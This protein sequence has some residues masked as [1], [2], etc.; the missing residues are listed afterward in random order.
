MDLRRKR[1]ITAMVVTHDIHAAK[2]FSDL[3]ILLDK[4]RIVAQGTFQDL[5]K[6]DN[7]FVTRFLGKG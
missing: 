2:T 5:R 4:G 7:E 3:L 6:N 1:A